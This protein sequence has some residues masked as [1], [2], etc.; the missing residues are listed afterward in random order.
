MQLVQKPRLWAFSAG[1]AGESKLQPLNGSRRMVGKSAKMDDQKQSSETDGNKRENS[2]LTSSWMW[3]V[4]VGKP[5]NPQRIGGLH[6]VY[7]PVRGWDVNRPLF[8]W[9]GWATV[10]TS[11]KRGEKVQKNRSWCFLLRSFSERGIN[12]NINFSGRIPGTTPGPSSR[13]EK[14][15]LGTFY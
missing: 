6:G 1:W 14:L 13:I 9:W 5:T 4:S 11:A 12:T 3:P 15:M 2:G 7:R 8:W 10:E